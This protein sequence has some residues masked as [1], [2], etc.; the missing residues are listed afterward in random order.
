[1]CLELTRC[2]LTLRFGIYAST[3][4]KVLPI[5]NDHFM[6]EL[7]GRSRLFEYMCQYILVRRHQHHPTSSPKAQM[8]I[9]IPNIGSPTVSPS[10]PHRAMEV[11]ALYL[12]YGKS[13]IFYKIDTKYQVSLYF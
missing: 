5:L 1:M 6:K 12:V 4:R 9:A 7:N 3:G 11:V 10:I 8:L 2:R 13:T